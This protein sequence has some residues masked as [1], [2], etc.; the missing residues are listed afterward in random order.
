[1]ENGFRTSEFKIRFKLRDV[2]KINPWGK[3]GERTLHW[4]ALTDG[5]YCIDTPAGRLLEHNNEFDPDLGEPWLDYYVVRLF[6]DLCEI[7]P[8]VSEQIPIDVFTRYFAWH[9]REGHRIEESDDEELYFTWYDAISWWDARKL[10][11]SYLRAAPEFRLWRTG[12][13]INLDWVGDEPWLPS[14]ARLTLPFDSVR[15]AVGQFVHELLAA[16]AERIDTIKNNNWQPRDGVLD[17]EG[18]VAEHTK[19]EEWAKSMLARVQE[20][21]WDLVRR[22]LDKL[23]A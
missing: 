1:M 18:L 22:S 7:W 9:A 2:D 11:L 13:E 20:T 4:F 10:D 8:F 17:I 14:R 21:D 12:S 6:E 19:R 5:V 16:M 3:P 15:D 23:G